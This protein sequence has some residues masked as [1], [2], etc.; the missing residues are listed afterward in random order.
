M[1]LPYIFLVILGT[2]KGNVA[3]LPFNGSSDDIWDTHINTIIYKHK[4]GK[5][6]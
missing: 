2:K 6:T 3:A 1:V 4:R 5:V